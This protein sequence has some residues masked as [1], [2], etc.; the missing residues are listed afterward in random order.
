[1]KNT[2]P[3]GWDLKVLSKVL[4]EKNY[5][6]T[7]CRNYHLSREQILSFVKYPNDGMA[8]R[9][10][11]ILHILITVCYSKYYITILIAAG[12]SNLPPHQKS[13]TNNEF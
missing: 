13:I 12:L 10:I 6:S 4:L 2:V 9:K 5:I 8:Q 11:N 1:M 3:S 7:R